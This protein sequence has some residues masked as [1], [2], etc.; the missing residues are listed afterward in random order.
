MY[1]QPSILCLLAVVLSLP[2]S[3]L[4]Q[5][6]YQLPDDF[7]PE[8]KTTVFATAVQP[9]GK[10]LVGRSSELYSGWGYYCSGIARLNSDGSPDSGFMANV[11]GN[12]Y[13]LAVQADGKIL[14]GGE[15]SE[16]NG[17][18]CTNLARLN[19]NG[20]LDNGF[21]ATGGVGWV[22]SLAVQVD[23]KILVGAGGIWRLNAGDGSLDTNFN[24]SVDGG[25]SSLVLQADGRF[26]VGGTFT[27]I[28]G[29]A[30]TNLARLN[31]ADGGLDTNFNASASGQVWSLALQADGKIVVGGMF[32]TL[33]GQTCYSI[34][35][36]NMEDGSLDTNFN[37]SADGDVRLLAVQGDGKILVGASLWNEGDVIWRLNAGDGSW[38][39]NFNASV[40][41]GVC[42]LALQADGKILVG[43]G[44]DSLSGQPRQSLGRL[45]NTEPAT[46]TLSCEDSTVTW[47]RGGPGPEVWRTTLDVTTNG[48]E[49]TPVGP[50]ARVSGGWQW[51]EVTLP[52]DGTFRA[53][54]CV[55][56]DGGS[57]S[58][59]LV[60]T[61]LGK[62]L[63]IAPPAGQTNDAGTTVK[64]SVYVG[65]SAPV[66]FQ[67]LKNEL[68]L[69]DGANIVGAASNALILSHV[70]RSDEGV[71]TVVVSNSYPS[72]ASASAS[73][74]V[75]DPAIAVQPQSQNVDGGQALTLSITA[76]GTDAL[77]YQWWKD[78]VAL[79]GETGASLTRVSAAVADG[80]SY[81]V[82]VSNQYGSVTSAVALVTVNLAS[83]DRGFNPE[84]PE[85]GGDITDLSVS[86]IALQPDGKIL[87]AR[88]YVIAGAGWEPHYEIA[89]LYPDGTQDPTFETAPYYAVALAVQADGRILVGGLTIVRLN[90]DGTL[91][92]GFT[93]DGRYRHVCSLAVQAD[94]KIL[95]GG[96][97]TRQSDG[98]PCNN[99]A[100]LNPNGTRDLSFEPD[101]DNEVNSLA[102]QADGKILVAGQFDT[103]AGQMCRGIGRLNAADGSLD[104]NFNAS[105]G[106]GVFS[107]VVQ[108]DGKIVVGGQFTTMGGL[109]L[110]NLAR[111]DPADGTA[112]SLF[113]LGWDDEPYAYGVSCLAVQANGKVVVGGHFTKVGGQTRTNLGRLNAADGSADSLFNPG[114]DNSVYGLAVQADGKILV[115]GRFTLLGGRACNGFG[116]LNNSESAAESL[117]FDGS[118]ITWLRDGPT[119]EIPS[120]TFDYSTNGT[121]W[122]CLGAGTNIVGGWQLT[123]L[124]PPS[125][126]WLRARGTVSGGYQNGSG[127]LVESYY[128]RLFF[129]EQP[130]TRTNNAGRTATFSVHV[131]GSAP[132]S[133]QWLKDG[134]PLVDEGNASGAFTATLTLRNVF[135]SDAA[136]YAVVVSNSF[137]SVT[138]AVAQLRVLEPVI[139]SQPLSL[140]RELGQ[141]ATFSVTA[142]G[143]GPLSY[144]WWKDGVALAGETG[145]SLTRTGLQAGDPGNYWV[146]VS[147]SYGITISAKAVL[148]VNLV[149]LDTGFNPGPDWCVSSLAVQADGKILAGGQ[150]DTLDGQTCHC[151]GRLN[152]DGTL[153]R[154]FDQVEEPDYHVVTAML[155]QSNGQIVVG[156]YFTKLGGLA[157]HNLARLNADWSLDGGFYP[158]PDAAVSSL[159]VQADGEILVSG[160]FGTLG[161]HTCRGIGRLNGADGGVDQGFNPGA[162]GDVESLAVQADGK[163]LLGG[164]LSAPGTPPFTNIARLNEDGSLDDSFTQGAGADGRVDDMLV[165]PDGKI[166][167]SGVFETIGG[168]ARNGL[169]RLNADGSVDS[170]FDPN[171]RGAVY[172]MVLQTDGK[173]LLGGYFTKVGGQSRTNLARLNADGTVDGSFDPGTDDL[174]YSLALQADGAI[175]VGGF[176]WNLGGQPC[177]YLGRLINTAPATQSLAA[178]TS[179]IT[180]LRGGTSPEIL[181]A[182][183]DYSTDGLTWINAGLGTQVVGGW[184]LTGLTLPAEPTVRARGTVS[185]SLGSGSRWFVET[186]CG[187]MLFLTQPVSRTNGATTTANFIVTAGGSSPV[188]FQWLRDGV[189]LED[190]GYISGSGTTT[191]TLG[192]VFRRDAG[193]YTVVASNS[194]GCVTS[195]VARLTVVDP[196]ITLQPASQT[197]VAGQDVTFSVTAVGTA[198]LS[199]QWWKDGV[200]LAAETGSSLTRTGLRAG[201]PGH[202]WVV[203]SN[204]SGSVTSDIVWLTVNLAA[205][206]GGFN[207]R[208]D[209]QV[210]SLAVQAD[211]K[212]L[213]GGWFDW[214]GGQY[215]YYMG[216]VGV[217]G[218]LDSGFD[219]VL[220]N[221]DGGVGT[222]L[223]QSNGQIVVSGNFLTMGGVARTNLA[224]LNAAGWSVDSGFD[225]KPNSPVAPMALQADGKILLGGWFD[226]VGG[227]PRTNLAR[228]N[229]DGTLDTTFDP[230]PDGQV[231]SLAIQADGKILVSGW[232]SSLGGQ[233]CT[234]LVRLNAN[235]TLD[236]GFDQGAG[237]N[238]YMTGL[239]V[240]SDGKILVCGN[241]SSLGGLTR[242]YLARLNADGT[243]DG[244]FDPEPNGMVT[245]LAL[246]A[247]GKIMLSG[248]FGTVGGQLRSY[249]ARLNADGSTDPE[250][251][252]EP[253]GPVYSLA[254]QADG[255]ILVGGTFSYFWSD[256]GNPCPYLG[257]LRNTGPATQSLSYDGATIHWFRGGS[258]PEVWGTSFDASTNG[259]DWFSL[260]AGTHIAGGWQLTGLPL[261]TNA[262]IRARGFVTGGQNNNSGW[263]VET[264]AN[265]ILLPVA[266][267]V[268]LDSFVGEAGD[269]NGNRP[270]TFKA[271]DLDGHVIGAWTLPLDFVGAMASYSLMNVPAETAHLS[272]K[273]PWSLRKRL[274]VT[275]GSDPTVANFTGPSKLPVGDLDDSNLVDQGDY[276]QLASSWYLPDAASDV[277][278][279]GLV[280]LDDYF[281]LTNHWL[282]RGD[283]E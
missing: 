153:D 239:A 116:R 184:Q 71:Y 131:G 50:G 283:P 176:F 199:Y 187:K 102:V 83:L 240:Q 43:G 48:D 121:D 227:Q 34:G 229:A 273:M 270:V 197:G 258:S 152:V 175:L 78:G 47:L 186:Y 90:E 30:R 87:V 221:T 61:Y 209:G 174:V 205:L 127:W 250:F 59:W 171:P 254:L 1:Q 173:I 234:H 13:S 58:S 142:F 169:A 54:G 191:L 115:G 215:C 55:A 32:H 128:G 201:D 140:H 196:L 180:W 233:P 231:H 252:P 194:F 134:V 36:L 280:D 108:A 64:F 206:D 182:S 109:A 168:L 198:P 157:C 178:D 96:L 212:I 247:D 91:D 208:V 183:F 63:I 56:E 145:A 69:T 37:A 161:G 223:V 177:Q 33:A 192:S 261:P 66:S 282:E 100:R 103:L 106:G 75:L 95:V 12:V 11:D 29:Q 40:D 248:Y 65:G 72:V 276:F 84:T 4:A 136:G 97:F 164:W 256:G 246:Q 281:L 98:A 57:S 213:V 170:D 159:A 275:F 222:M 244:E 146:V 68:P 117:N 224:R 20:S 44:F 107:M 39:T 235:G 10:I 236:S 18:F 160:I 113:K 14:V 111:L 154:G 114:A 144:Q 77:I 130:V 123:G 21:S 211:G 88:S 124:T 243:V 165:Q 220:E 203:V 122:V 129:L 79:A 125:D 249:L 195:E 259:T 67:W 22:R 35:R 274:P 80:G 155:V 2:L 210:N 104:T 28:N 137:G 49:W 70:L 6:P 148:T 46:Q 255:A 99:L 110:T 25:V 216:R 237:A 7:C 138:S 232:F 264:T 101:P 51:S 257:R 118:T 265:A 272:A 73:L 262:T 207:P 230:A 143:S 268:E 163:I 126:A 27:G 266:G 166:L 89:R 26:V 204:S 278:G 53:R 112:D 15:F 185:G 181:C 105:A 158:E 269:G 81:W 60:E 226:S 202:Y 214:L 31:A 167:V 38:D 94:G 24:V 52:P 147:D 225:P 74:K 156:G 253:D 62:I 3:G 279:N 228:L 218:N 85:P 241:F 141:D 190:G 16:V 42:S 23:G 135:A 188:T 45:N 172:S 9:D 238:G 120:A 267:Q 86:A 132:M 8:M 217:D 93:L 271:T 41:G 251:A 139:T 219:P 245:S 260:G 76:E 179:T 133:F 17:Q 242:N 92:S 149:N 263:F 19:P 82:A 277:D 189:P 200:A 151:V 150:F 162:D 119:P 5:T 193:G